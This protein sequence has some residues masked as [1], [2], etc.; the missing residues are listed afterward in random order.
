M[1]RQHWWRCNGLCQKRPPYYGMVKRAM[2][3]APAERD[4]WWADHQRTCGGTYIKVKE[5]EDYG[6]KKRKVKDDINSSSDESISSHQGM[7]KIYDFWK[8]ETT[9]DVN[10]MTKDKENNMQ[11]SNVETGHA[12]IPFCGKGTALG[13]ST[14]CKTENSTC[15]TENSAKTRP[16]LSNVRSVKV[17]KSNVLDLDHGHNPKNINIYDPTCSN[18]TGINTNEQRK[19]LHGKAKKKRNVINTGGLTIVDAF[20]RVKETKSPIIIIDDSPSKAEVS[21][22][23]QNLVSCPVCQTNIQ[24]NVMNSHLDT[25]LL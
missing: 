5:P 2:N 12:F 4:P 8:N 1:Y 6:K 23:F 16:L 15:K 21:S 11:K 9:T 10:T 19:K 22:D 25:C 17:D 14:S 3:R 7:P 18:S 20:K 24:K 13:D